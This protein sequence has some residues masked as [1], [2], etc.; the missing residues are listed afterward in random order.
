MDSTTVQAHILTVCCATYPRT[1]K[2]A[3]KLILERFWGVEVYVMLSSR[4]KASAC[5]SFMVVYSLAYFSILMMEAIC[6]FEMSV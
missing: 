3:E 6:S 1:L 5:C 4:L 2:L